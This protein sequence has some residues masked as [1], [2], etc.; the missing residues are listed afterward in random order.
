MAGAALAASAVADYW[1]R[2]GV[3]ATA[4]RLTPQQFA[5]QEYRATFPAFFVGCGPND[6]EGLRFLYSSQTRLPTNNF[7]IAGPGNSS[8]YINPEFDALL[9]T[10]SKTLPLPERTQAFGRIIHHIADQVTLVGL[11]Y[12][13]IPAAASGRM[14]NVSSDWLTLFI[15]WN[16]HEWDVRS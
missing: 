5:D 11:Y 13:P 14:L 12:N 6:V 1:Q 9:D 16:A 10:Y 3:D 15:N 2:L 7:R 4:V 8:R